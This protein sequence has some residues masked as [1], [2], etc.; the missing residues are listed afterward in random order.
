MAPLSPRE[1]YAQDLQRGDFVHDP[2]QA[3]AV[4]ALQ[5]IH[6]DSASAHCAGTQ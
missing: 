2:A 3:R 1:R 6:D 5:R 4:D